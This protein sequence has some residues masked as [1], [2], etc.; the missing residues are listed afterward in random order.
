MSA[1]RLPWLRPDAALELDTNRPRRP[2]A[3][4]CWDG[5][6]RREVRDQGWRPR[7]GPGGAARAGARRRRDRRRPHCGDRRGGAGG[8]RATASGGR[9]LRG[10]LRQR[11]PRCLPAAR[12]RGHQHPRRAHQRHS[13]AGAGANPGRRAAD[14]RGGGRPARRALA[15]LG[16]GRLPGPGADAGR[17]SGSSGWDAS[18]A[19]TPS[20]SRASPARSCTSAAPARRMPSGS[21]ASGGWR[22]RRSSAART[23]S[24][25]ICRRP[26][27]RP[28]WSGRRELAA[29]KPRGDPRQHVARAAGRLE[30]AG[31]G[32]AGGRDRRRGP[33]RL[34][35]RARRSHRAARGAP[36][37]PVAPIGSATTRA[38][39]GMARLVAENVLAVL[40]GEEPPNRV[41]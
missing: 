18:G 41:V 24:A 3:P 31:P 32:A 8:G 13:G 4:A 5:A 40:D 15:G 17:R 35:A 33:R 6:A 22:W 21:W 37:C 1:A 36:L 30:G 34:R 7:V 25:S 20:W 9:Q 26:A 19:A 12:R 23:W 2:P 11:R 14:D 38:R 39:D 16:P 29:M 28:G 27:K 10:R